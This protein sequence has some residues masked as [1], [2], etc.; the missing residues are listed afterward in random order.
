MDRQT[1]NKNLHP[2]HSQYTWE[3]TVNASQELTKKM[4]KMF[5][6]QG[7]AWPDM[8]LYTNLQDWAVPLPSELKNDIPLP[9]AELQRLTSPLC[10]RMCRKAKNGYIELSG[11]G[12]VMLVC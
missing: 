7:N 1:D 5:F 6:L 12:I 9:W 11:I 10:R 3:C 8:V 2:Q 4:I